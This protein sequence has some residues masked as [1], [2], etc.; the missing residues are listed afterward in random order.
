MS[1][2]YDLGDGIDP[3]EKF[4]LYHQW[5]QLIDVANENFGAIEWQPNRMY[6]VWTDAQVILLKSISYAPSPFKRAAALA[7]AF[8][9]DDNYPISGEF[10]THMFKNDLEEHP[11]W[12]GAFLMIEYIRYA[13][14]GAHIIKGGTP[15]V[16]E[17][18]IKISKHT[19]IDIIQAF[20]HLRKGCR[21]DF[22]LIALL[23][24]QLVYQENSVSYPREF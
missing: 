7:I 13:L 22:Y 8:M 11:K 1:N 5:R 2:K 12:S 9:D 16:L 4:T 17:S 18:P 3:K 24:E 20:T 10:E 6:D 21:A 14:D 15:C 19:Y 23:I